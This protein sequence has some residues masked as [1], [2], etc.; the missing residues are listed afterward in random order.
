MCLPS[1]IASSSDTPG[2]SL[3][4]PSFSVNMPT[5]LTPSSPSML[6]IL[7]WVMFFCFINCN[8]LLNFMLL[9]SK[10]TLDRQSSMVINPSLLLSKMRNNSCACC[11]VISI[12]T[13]LQAYHNSLSFNTPVFL[14]ANKQKAENPSSELYPWSFT[15]VLT[16]RKAILNSLLNP[17][18]LLKPVCAIRKPLLSLS[19]LLVRSNMRVATDLS[20]P[21]T[22]LFMLL[23]SKCRS[24][25]VCKYLLAFSSISKKSCVLPA[26]FEL[27]SAKLLNFFRLS[28][29]RLMFPLNLRSST[30]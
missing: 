22:D 6:T 24:N 17:V 5:L 13:P 30:L 8:N 18:D 2:H 15:H 26:N 9:W 12:D 25:P 20:K 1:I 19:D 29:V 27:I 4:I 16:M 3:T 14:P 11:S 23:S 21:V 7:A 28:A 10:L